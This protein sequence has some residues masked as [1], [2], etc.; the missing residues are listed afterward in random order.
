MCRDTRTTEQIQ[1]ALA[2]EAALA[3][4]IAA[5]PMASPQDKALHDALHDQMNTE[6]TELDNRR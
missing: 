1:G 3:R 2:A 4:Q 6:L 5:D